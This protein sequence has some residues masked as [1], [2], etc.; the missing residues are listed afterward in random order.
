M[1]VI[2]SI[3]SLINEDYEEESVG[4]LD[5]DQRKIQT[6]QRNQE[7]ADLVKATDDCNMGND[8]V[9]FDK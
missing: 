1:S 3:D 8:D 5:R 7:Q 6:H 2:N 4:G 9:V